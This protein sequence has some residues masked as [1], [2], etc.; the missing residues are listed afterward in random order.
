M[1]RI[2]KI[3]LLTTIAAA[4]AWVIFQLLSVPRTGPL[5]P[6]WLLPERESYRFFALGDTG[7]GDKDQYAVAEAM[8]VRC[9][10]GSLDG[11]L[12]LGDNFYDDGVGST[13]D[14]QW[15]SKVFKPYGSACLS[16]VPIY[17]LLGNHD[18]K[19]DVEVQMQMSEI[20]PRW[21]LPNRNYTLNFGNILKIIAVDTQFP[22]VCGNPDKCTV[23]YLKKSLGE[24]SPSWTI[25]MGHHPF[26]TSSNYYPYWRGFKEK[27]RGKLFYPTL[28][29]K[30]DAYLSGHSHH[31]EH[32][33][34]KN[35]ETEQFISGG[36]GAALYPL[37]STLSPLVRFAQL[38]YGYLE[39]KANADVLTWTFLSSANEE[40]YQTE[41][42][43]EIKST[44]ERLQTQFPAP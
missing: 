15:E 44:H 4:I 11:I 25:V 23:D 17:A 42:T 3:I 28:C 22:D 2:L 19:G 13:T 27:I 37:K 40:L 6:D 5:S 35:C 36:G 1:G 29:G 39:I 38:T 34:L 32:R 20:N 30:A 31:L 26:Q 10:E 33:G 12:L 43:T 41:M 9:Q 21:V 8:E 14:P 18:Y 24:G 7:T 16:Q